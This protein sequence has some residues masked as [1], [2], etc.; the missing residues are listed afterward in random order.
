MEDA[1]IAYCGAVTAY[2]EGQK[3]DLDLAEAYKLTEGLEGKNTKERAAKLR[4]ELVQEYQALAEAKDIQDRF[5]APSGLS[6][7]LQT[8]ANLK[9]RA[10]ISHEL[11]TAMV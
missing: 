1:Q 4:L 8:Y 5:F 7:K 10:G 6:S 9:V 3:R 2:A 11:K